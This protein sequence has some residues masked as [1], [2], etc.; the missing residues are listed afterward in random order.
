MPYKHSA[1]SSARAH[2][3]TEQLEQDKEEK[4]IWGNPLPPGETTPVTRIA[5]PLEIAKIDA[6]PATA[7]YLFHRDGDG[8]LSL[9]LEENPNDPANDGQ[10]LIKW[11]SKGIEKTRYFHKGLLY[12]ELTRLF[13]QC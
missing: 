3:P 1:G 6:L 5:D 8:I 2:I 4:P 7:V 12:R 11:R 10:V 9:E 13:S